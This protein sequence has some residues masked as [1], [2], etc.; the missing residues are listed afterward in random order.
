MA[1][2]A[3]LLLHSHHRATDGSQRMRCLGGRK[4]GDVNEIQRGLDPGSHWR[5]PL[6]Y[7]S[8]LREKGRDVKGVSGS[9][10]KAEDRK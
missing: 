1:A 3:D 5:L 2:E 4:K 9:L 7:R 8:L 10:E 6:C